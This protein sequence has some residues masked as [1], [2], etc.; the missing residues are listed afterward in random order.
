MTERPGFS[1]STELILD[2]RIQRNPFREKQ[3]VFFRGKAPILHTSVPH[4][5]ST[6]FG[7]ENYRRDQKAVLNSLHT[8]TPENV[9]PDA[10]K[11]AW[12]SSS[13]FIGNRKILLPDKTIVKL[14]ATDQGQTVIRWMKQIGP[15]FLKLPVFKM[16]GYFVIDRV[17]NKAWDTSQ[18]WNPTFDDSK[19]EKRKPVEVFS[20]P[21]I[22][23]AFFVPTRSANVLMLNRLSV[24]NILGRFL[25]SKTPLKNTFSIT[26]SLIPAHE[27]GHRWQ[28]K[29]YFPV[30]EITFKPKW[31]KLKTRL[32]PIISKISPSWG[33]K[34][35][36]ELK[37]FKTHLSQM[38]RN[39]T[40]FQLA[41][42]H[43]LRGKGVDLLRG[44][45]NHE[46]FDAVNFSL[47]SYDKAYSSLP[48]PA[49]SKNAHYRFS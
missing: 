20:Y 4:F 11:P 43:K 33:E 1:P 23:N 22:L 9:L 42:A 10:V 46:V 14:S 31:M 21:K 30:D 40:A 45:S 5:S 38:E 26:D 27:S 18:L 12:K 3:G 13:E 36:G 28:F 24:D 32:L 6:E 47:G 44:Y 29:D 48:G 39:A 2:R 37:T 15:R 34:I 16:L 19:N 41:V 35:Y 25:S 49:F 8:D 17:S 7:N